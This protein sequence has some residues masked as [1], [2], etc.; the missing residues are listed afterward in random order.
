MIQSG[1][2]GGNMKLQRKTEEKIEKI[3]A[4][5]EN[6]STIDD[7]VKDYF[8]RH[9]KK[10]S[11]FLENYH[12][13]IYGAEAVKKEKEPEEIKAVTHHTPKAINPLEVLFKNEEEFQDFRALLGNSKELLGLL[14]GNG[15]EIQEEINVLEVPQE[16][17]KMKDL[18]VRSQRLS[19]EVEKK[20]DLLLEK[21]PEYSKTTLI[22]LALLE[23]AEKYL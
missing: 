8:G 12:H 1:I 6:G 13:L 15:R 22:N 23:F 5:L 3:K 21:F 11:E 16:L 18:R 14:K 17:I 10:C 7:L 9:R 20:F 4:A 2:A 19:E